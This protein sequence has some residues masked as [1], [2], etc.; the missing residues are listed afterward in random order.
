IQNGE[1]GQFTT[2]E[3]IWSDADILSPENFLYARIDAFVS[4]ADQNDFIKGLCDLARLSV[5]K[6]LPSWTHNQS[7]NFFVSSSLCCFINCFQN[8]FCF[9]YHAGTATIRAIIYDAMFI[10]NE[11]ARIDRFN[12]NELLVLCATEDR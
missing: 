9:E 5:V 7:S 3:H 6:L 11:I 12:C 2:C 1:R 4:P 8:R 10:V